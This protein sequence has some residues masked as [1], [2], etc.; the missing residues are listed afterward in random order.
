MKK[1]I[2]ITLLLACVLLLASCTNSK[3]ARV[4]GDY[5]TSALKGSFISSDNEAYQIGE[6]SL[7]RPVFRDTDKAWE[8]FI[9]DYAVG[10]SAIQAAFNLDLISKQDYRFYLTYGLDMPERA[11][12]AVEEQCKDVSYFL[13]IYK[14]S[15]R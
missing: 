12:A 3:Y 4:V 1:H 8:A 14:N 2:A 5:D 10:I 15:F 13:Q 11:D 6:N 7:G 9:K